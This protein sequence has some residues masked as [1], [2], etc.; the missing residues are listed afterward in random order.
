MLVHTVK[1]GTY[2]RTLRPPHEKARHVS[3]E[4]LAVSNTGQVCVY[5]QHWLKSKS[6]DNLVSY[7]ASN[8]MIAMT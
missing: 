8:L 6:S 7:P 2:L 5:C 1:H 4:R 3:I